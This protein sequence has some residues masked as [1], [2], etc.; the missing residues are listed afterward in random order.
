[1][2]FLGQE[3]FDEVADHAQL[4]QFARAVFLV[5]G[6]IGIGRLNRLAA[7]N[8]IL[9]PDAFR[10]VRE[11]KSVEAALHVS[12]L[13]AI[14]NPPHK[15]L[16]KRRAGDHSELA[17]FGHRLGKTPVGD[18]YTHAALNDFGK[19]HHLWILSQVR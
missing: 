2:P 9:L 19:L 13:V 3:N 17:E 6:D 7:G 11:R 16:V 14:G 1:V 4:H 8:K 15:E 12:A 18:A 10:H 5:H